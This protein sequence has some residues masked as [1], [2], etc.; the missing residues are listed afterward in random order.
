MYRVSDGEKGQSFSICLDDKLTLG[1]VKK[2]DLA[3][4]ELFV[5]RDVALDDETA[6]NLALQCRLKTI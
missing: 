4:D 6:A 3:K 2:L 1:V 5:C